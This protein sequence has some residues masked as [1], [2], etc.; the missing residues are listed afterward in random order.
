MPAT[1]PKVYSAPKD[2]TAG[3][4][5]PTLAAKRLVLTPF[6]ETDIPALAAILR[7]PDVAKGIMTNG[8]TPARARRSAAERIA[9]HNAT[10]GSHGYG[11]W[12]IR[13]APG[14]S[15]DELA[16]KRQAK[17]RAAPQPGALIG[18]CGFTKPDLGLEPELLYGLHPHYWHQGLAA[19]AA[20]AA[21]AWLFST[22]RHRGAAAVIFGRI[23]PPS[24]TLIQHLGFERKGRLAMADF[25]ANHA[26]ARDIVD[27]ETWR[28][29][30]SKTGDPLRLLF[31]APFKAGQ[32][33]SLFPNERS[34]IA[35]ALRTAASARHDLPDLDHPERLLRVR[36]AFEQGLSQPWLDWWLKKR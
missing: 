5:I 16:A 28:L 7:E 19:E 2:D 18:W 4:P 29:G 24:T 13:L 6:R 26:L 1:G 15:G 10:W 14:S 23:N 9:W 25:M 17:R 31:E 36:D 21:L 3:A 27:Y 35:D 12:A 30:K 32:I 34:A 33:A 8:A 11:I 20:N 22:T